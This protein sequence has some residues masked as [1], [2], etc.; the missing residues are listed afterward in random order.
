MN[1]VKPVS[2]QEFVK[3]GPVA[4]GNASRMRHVAKGSLQKAHQIVSLKF[5]ACIF[6]RR[7][8]LCV[9]LSNDPIDQCGRNGS[10]EGQRN[11][12]LQDIIQLSYVSGPMRLLK[13]TERVRC[14][15]NALPGGNSG[16]K[17]GRQEWNILDSF[18][19]RRYLQCH[20]A[21]QIEKVAAKLTLG[22][23]L[24]QRTGA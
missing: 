1:W 17:M 3:L 18:A 10:G 7:E 13:R 22:H 14:Q 11:D 20:P 21:Q 19:T 16:E 24:V 8:A 23:R 6:D 5:P 12:L 2:G 9:V 4:A 15:R